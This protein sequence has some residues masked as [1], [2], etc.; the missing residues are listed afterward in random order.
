MALF[1]RRADG[2]YPT[3]AGETLIRHARD[4]FGTLQRAGEEMDTLAGGMS[5]TLSIGSNFSSAADLLPR[6][7]VLLRRAHPGVA[8]SVR[9]ASLEVLLPALRARDIDVVVARWT[10]ARRIGDLEE[11]ALFEQPMC[12]VCAPNNPLARAK[13]VSWPVLARHPW[14]LPPQ[15]S[16]VRD[17]LEELFRL[18]RIRPSEAGIECAS[19]FA[20]TILM[21]EL[22]AVAV[23]PAA[24]ARHLQAARLLAI[25]PARMPP[26]FG[27]NSAI[28]LRER[29]HSPAMQAFLAA[30]GEAA[31]T[32]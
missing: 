9:E 21:R 3:P 23:A 8:V 29:E 7:I 4:V 2:T 12:V 26:V 32:R 31:R 17:D 5:G 13:T 11:H 28:T 27:P 25:L 18:Q 30:L 6:A 24:V 19:A 14:I 10:R 16:A 20:N 15:G 22:D 1:E